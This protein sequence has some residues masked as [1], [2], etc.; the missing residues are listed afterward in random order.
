MT[1]NGIKEID[2]VV[3]N[4][5]PFVETISKKETTRE[6]AIENIDIG[7]PSM[8]RSAAKNNLYVGVVVEP[9]NYNA[10]LKELSENDGSLTFKTR[11]ELAAK[12]FSHTAN[13]DAAISSYLNQQEEKI[14]QYLFGKYELKQELR[15]GENPHQSAAFYIDPNQLGVSNISSAEQLQGKELSYNNIADTDAAYECVKNFSEPACVIVKHAN[16]C[17]IALGKSLKE[18]YER[19]FS[20]DETSA[21]GGIIAFNGELDEETSKQI[22]DNQFVEVIIAPGVSQGAR[23]IIS[24][25]ENIRLLDTKMLGDL[26]SGSKIL[27][28][29]GGLLIQDNDI[30]G[31]SREDLKI[32]STRLPTD[33]E[34]NNCLFAWKVCKYVKSNAIVYTR[35]NQTIGIGAGQMSRIDSA[36]IA[37]SKALERGFETQGCSMAS[38]AFFSI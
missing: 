32:V 17:G 10:V 21:F 4:L 13:Y 29:S 19:A 8:V 37:A 1:D 12:A 34:I 30:A 18:A 3:V 22:I 23:N 36:K 9:N 31:L 7:G 6:I 11:R 20:S 16:P 33:E 26:D 15:Y 24:T 38:D 27:S 25:K 35:N 28:V 2:L 5:Y 14:P